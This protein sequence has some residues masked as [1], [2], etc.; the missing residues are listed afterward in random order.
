[1]YVLFVSH[2]RRFLINLDSEFSAEDLII[3]IPDDG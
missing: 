2:S 1:M 3:N